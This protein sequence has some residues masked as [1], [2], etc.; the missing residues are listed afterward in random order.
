MWSPGIPLSLQL[1]ET[2][3]TRCVDVQELITKQSLCRFTHLALGTDRSPPVERHAERHTS[4]VAPAT[5]V[6]L[7]CDCLLDK[8]RDR[9]GIVPRF[10]QNEYK[11][12]T[13][14]TGSW[15][16]FDRKVLFSISTG[17]AGARTA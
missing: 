7:G 16:K 3:A 1:L 13:S 9:R 17:H 15:G 6:A 11:K 5:L 8:Q 10:P 14:R 12:L 4:L 2:N